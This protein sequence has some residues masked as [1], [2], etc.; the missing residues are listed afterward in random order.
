[1]ITLEDLTA[2]EERLVR[3]LESRPGPL[4]Q[5]DAQWTRTGLYAEYA[6]VFTGYADLVEAG[7]TPEER[8]E[9]LKRA[10]FLLW[11]EGAEPAPLSGL[12]ELPESRVLHILTL[13]E[14]LCIHDGLDAELRWML[15]WYWRHA[16]HALL[17]V[18]GLACLEAL[19]GQASPDWGAWR[20]APMPAG[21][22][23]GRGSM[24]R[25]WQSVRRTG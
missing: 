14:R 2:W 25:Y 16:G 23:G 5:R 19:L 8:L 18:A 4:E 17:R 9:A 21:V 20:Q 1:L 6:A 7:R 13:L 3:Q 15:P 11:Y 22:F 10:V 12:A 24:G